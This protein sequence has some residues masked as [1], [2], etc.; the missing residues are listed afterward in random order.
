M[1]LKELTVRWDMLRESDRFLRYVNQDGL[2]RLVVEREFPDIPQEKGAMGYAVVTIGGVTKG[3]ML[4][5]R[6]VGPSDTHPNPWVA[7]LVAAGTRW[8]LVGDDDI[9]E[10]TP[11]Q[12]IPE[13]L[14]G[15]LR[16]AIR[17]AIDEEGPESMGSLVTAIE[18]HVWDAL[19]SQ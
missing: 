14:P 8:H 4:L 16:D 6:A 11:M 9:V 10:F 15:D 13:V 3:D 18:R 17:T 5:V 1:R 2:R 19:K 12:L 7:P